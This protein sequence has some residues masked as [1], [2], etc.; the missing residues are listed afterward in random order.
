[1]KSGIKDEIIWLSS[2][3]IKL[4]KDFG[5][6]SIFTLKKNEDDYKD[7]LRWFCSV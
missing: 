7:M 4:D 2:K 5:I 1:M 3:F 6:P